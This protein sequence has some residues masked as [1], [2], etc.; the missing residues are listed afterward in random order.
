MKRSELVVVVVVG[1]VANQ[2][3]AFVPARNSHVQSR[4]T[5]TTTTTTQHTSFTHARHHLF[6]ILDDM[7]ESANDEVVMS[8]SILLANH[9]EFQN[10]YHDLIFSTDLSRQIT[11]TLGKCTNPKFL[12]FLYYL[13]EYARRKR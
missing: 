12:V 10:L 9:P 13:Q 11:K 2:S 7:S 8:E 4:T 3:Y 1:I 5:T 6:G